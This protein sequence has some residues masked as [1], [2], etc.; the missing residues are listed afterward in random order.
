MVLPVR[1]S[2]CALALALGLAACAPKSAPPA[3]APTRIVV[4]GGTLTEVVFALGMGDAVV[5]VD[6][7]ARYPEA[8]V[9]KPKAGFY[10]QLSAEGVL[11]L[12]PDLILASEETGPA[13]AVAQLTAAGI[14]YRSFANPRSADSTRALIKAVGAALGR[15]A[16]A[17]SLVAQLNQDLDSLRG[18]TAAHPAQPRVLFIYARGAGTVQVGGRGTSAEAIVTLA[19]CTNA[20][21]GFENYKPLTPEAVV[22][23]NP[24]YI[25]LTD[26]GLA[27]IG[28]LKG[29]QALPGLAQSPAVRTGRVVALNDLYLL[30]F[31][32]RLGQAALELAQLTH[33]E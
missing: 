21:T 10:R 1:L 7:S 27:S 2:C 29:L 8:A 22:E 11:G 25:L 4:L 33:P 12:S 30:G 3:Q 13:D 9:A 32:P 31:G 26:S 23:A 6:E 17:D 20:A 28:G 19:G 5:G 16:Q 18:F 15:R 14:A 24:D